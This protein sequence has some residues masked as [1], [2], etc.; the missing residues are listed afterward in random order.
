MNS[1]SRLKPVAHKRFAF[2]GSGFRKLRISRPLPSFSA[3][4]RDIDRRAQVRYVVQRQQYNFVRVSASIRFGDGEQPTISRPPTMTSDA[5]GSRRSG[6]VALG[7]RYRHNKGFWARESAFGGR[8]LLQAPR[9]CSFSRTHAALSPAWSATTRQIRR[10]T[11]SHALG[12]AR[13]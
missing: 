11:R 8:A 9:L 3:A 1:N 7:R 4:C 6:A 13:L 5:L 2:A 12:L 10:S